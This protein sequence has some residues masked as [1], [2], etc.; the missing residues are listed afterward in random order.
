LKKVR[1]ETFR[2]DL[3][4]DCLLGFNSNPLEEEELNLIY[5]NY[6][7]ISPMMGIGKSKYRGI[8]ET[9]EEYCS[10]EEK[11]VDIG[12]CDGYLLDE[13][14]RGGYKDLVGIDRSPQ[15]E[16]A[17]S[18]GLN[19]MNDYF[20]DVVFP[21][22]SVDCFV[23]MHVFEH[24]K[25]PFAVLEKIKTQLCL[26]GKIILEVPYFSGYHHHHL[27]FYNV[28]FLRRLCFEKNL[29]IVRMDFTQDRES[30]RVVLMHGVDGGEPRV[31]AIEASE[32]VFRLSSQKAETFKTRVANLRS[33]FPKL[34]KVYWWG[35][36][37]SS[38][39]YLNQ[40]KEH[41]SDKDQLSIID[42]DKNKWGLYIPGINLKVNPFIVLK[43]K[44]VDHLIVASSFLE[45]IK[46]TLSNNQIFV[47]SIEELV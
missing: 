7:Y 27:F 35:A 30:L 21:E 43:G 37:S 34:K 39:I 20:E 18:K 36:G 17:K 8:L 12:C 23:M 16:I 31:K 28:A 4:K 46:E 32:D 11:I 13:L 6:L 29:K 15:A 24:F 38:V 1:L 44:S 40:I 22:T 47:K 2:A 33:A 41:I 14:A 42:G 45:E 9:I 26:T 25:D 3:C 5:S 19:V 10:K